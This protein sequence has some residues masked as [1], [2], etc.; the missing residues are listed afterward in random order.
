MVS[1]VK[2][3]PF[4]R[5]EVTEAG[6]W[7]WTGPRRARGYGYAPQWTGETVAT[8]L[9]YKAFKGPIPE[10]MQVCHSC[11]NPPCVNPD[12][13]WLGSASENLADAISKGRFL[14]RIK[15]TRALGERASRTKLT[16]AQV[17]AIRKD[18]RINRLVAR[19]YGIHRASV[20]AIKLRKTWG[21]LPD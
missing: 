21:W 14:H 5:Y 3:D 16:E 7:E 10:G 17:I 19:D 8:R 12:H 9:F 1:V 20:S 11:D 2:N 4:T 15:A 6:C 18:P 13:L